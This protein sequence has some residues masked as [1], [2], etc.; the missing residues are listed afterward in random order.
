MASGVLA[1]ARRF[2]ELHQKRWQLH[3]AQVDRQTGQTGP[4]NRESK[5]PFETVLETTWWLVPVTAGQIVAIAVRHQ[6][7][8]QIKGRQPADS[9]LPIHRLKDGKQEKADVNHHG[10]QNH[11]TGHSPL[12]LEAAHTPARSHSQSQRYHYPAQRQHGQSLWRYVRAGDGQ[13]DDC[14]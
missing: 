7:V 2:E 14:R 5:N 13:K 8:A 9:F 6:R 3:P 4:Q 12:K 10:G 11:H 1:A